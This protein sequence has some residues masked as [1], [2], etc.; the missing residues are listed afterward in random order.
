MLDYFTLLIL[1]I[2]LCDNGNS[3]RSFVPEDL[4]RIALKI[5]NWVV[6]E[7]TFAKEIERNF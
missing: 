2:T 4:F 6:V 7:R 5:T 3:H 1:H